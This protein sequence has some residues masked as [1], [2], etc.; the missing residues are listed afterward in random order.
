MTLH[1]AE[2]TLPHF[3]APGPAG[4]PA[5]ERHSS[6]VAPATCPVHA[7]WQAIPLPPRTIDHMSLSSSRDKKS[8]SFI[9]TSLSITIEEELGKLTR[10]KYKNNLHFGIS[11]LDAI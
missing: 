10:R 6:E 3:P 7:G 9:Y 8:V 1:G 5:R 4:D 11:A 2:G